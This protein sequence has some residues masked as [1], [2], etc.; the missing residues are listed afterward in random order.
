MIERSAEARKVLQELDTDLAASSA[1][2]GTSLVWTAADR[3]ILDA[4]AAN[5]DRRVDLARDYESSTEAKVRVKL[6]AE[7]RLLE[8][9]LARLLRQV[10]TDVPAPESQTTIK[11]RRAANA[12]RESERN[13]TG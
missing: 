3:A 5:I 6:S 2:A 11:A 4:I 7:L 9:A 8:G 10:Q 1:R 12:H 13:A